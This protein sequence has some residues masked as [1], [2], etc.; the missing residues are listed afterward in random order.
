MLECFIL[1]HLNATAASVSYLNRFPERQQPNET[2]FKRLRNNLIDHGSFTKERP[3]KYNIQDCDEVIEEVIGIVSANPSISSREI[4]AE[5]GIKRSRAL[6]ILKK[7]K[8]RPYAIRK[9]HSLKPGDA[10]RRLQF[11]NWFLDKIRQQPDFHRKLIWSDE[12]YISSAGIFNRHNEHIWADSNPHSTST[13]QRQGRFGFSV[14]CALFDSQV[15]AYEIYDDNLN[16]ENYHRIINENLIENYLDNIPLAQRREIFFQQDGAPPHQRRAVSDLLNSNFGLN[17]IGNTGPI[18]WP[19]RS[20]D[21]SPMDFFLWGHIKNLLYK[22]SNTTA[23]ELRQ[24]FIN[25]LNSVSN[26][27]ILNAT[28][29]VIRRCN[30]CI[31]NDGNNFEHLM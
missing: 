6:K 8:F 11:S 2:I 5:T 16:G 18:R 25:C 10:Q 22:K 24:N 1:N 27:H 7:H 3:K 14:W 12:T 20:P 30:L 23:D 19:P 13:V 9:I 17:W 26:I 28:R 21:L 31:E 29:D 15:L 4:Q